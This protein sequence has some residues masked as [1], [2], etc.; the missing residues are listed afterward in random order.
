L[1]FAAVM[2]RIYTPLSQIAGFDYDDLRVIAWLCWVPN[3]LVAQLLVRFARG[4]ADF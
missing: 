2:L 1:A 3:L 4:E